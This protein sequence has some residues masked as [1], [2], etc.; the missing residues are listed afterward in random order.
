MKKER[1]MEFLEKRVESTKDIYE[2][3]NH[4]SYNVI[5]CL[6]F[7]AQI[8]IL[9]LMNKETATPK[10]IGVAVKNHETNTISMPYNLPDKISSNR[11]MAR[12]DTTQ[13]LQ[14]F[15][16]LRP[17]LPDQNLRYDSMRCQSTYRY[18]TLQSP[19]TIPNRML[20]CLGPVFHL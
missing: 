15:T 6:V 1:D 3:R 12:T 2:E 4:F 18:L 7:A 17:C 11:Q 8:N 16:G 5:Q 14:D 19:Y 13:I 20:P 9:Q 10:N